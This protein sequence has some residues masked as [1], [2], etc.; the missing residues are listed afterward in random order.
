MSDIQHVKE[1]IE[2]GVDAE[3]LSSTERRIANKFLICRTYGKK[4]TVSLN[5]K[6]VLKE[7]RYYGCFTLT[8]NEK[9][10]T[11]TALKEYRLRERTEEGFRLDKQY[12]DAHVTR[13]KTTPSLEGR[14][15]CQFIA[16]GYESPQFS[17]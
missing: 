4:L 17:K 14:L 16:Y 5:D 12:N 13:S 15:F 1:Q 11:F 2:G 7:T 10:E 9:M 6:A 8:S 3:L